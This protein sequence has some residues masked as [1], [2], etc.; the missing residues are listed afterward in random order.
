[1][2]LPTYLPSLMEALSEVADLSPAA[3]RSSSIF[4]HFRT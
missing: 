4:G 1:M 3:W 2:P